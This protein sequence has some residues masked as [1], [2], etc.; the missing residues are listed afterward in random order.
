VAHQKAGIDLSF[1]DD[2][3]DL[4]KKMVK[5]SIEHVLYGGQ[6]EHFDVPETLKVKFG[7]FVT[8]KT[9]GDLK[10]CIGYIR[11]KM[12]L[13]QTIRQMA[14]EAAFHDPR[15]M[16]LS[17][18]EWKNTEI[19]ISVLTPMKKMKS[20]DEIE[21]GIHGL[22]IES[23]IDSGL[24]LPQVATEHGWDRQTFLEY[25]CMKAGL[26]PDAWKSEDSTV[27][28]FSADVF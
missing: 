1:T 2:E 8:L 25:T 16:P 15:F 21:I 18:E 24:L 10:G 22:Y 9:K 23:G 11:G 26:K 28:L 7:A 14:V 13:D 20:P 4:L 19:E 3:R 6:E 5:T 17:K 12:P 27:Y